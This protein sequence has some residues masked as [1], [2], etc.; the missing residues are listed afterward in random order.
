MN[1][2]DMKSLLVVNCNIAICPAGTTITDDSTT[3]T[4]SETVAPD[5]PS[6]TGNYAIAAPWERIG[7]VGDGAETVNSDVATVAACEDSGVWSNEPV[8]VSV[9]PTF[10]LRMAD[11]TQRVFQLMFGLPD[12]ALDSADGGRPW[13]GP[14]SIT[15]WLYMRISDARQGGARLLHGRMYGTLRL[16]TPPNIAQEIG[17][18]E[19]EFTPNV[20]VA[21]NTI[22]PLSLPPSS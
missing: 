8:D 10:R 22:V 2:S 12:G 7:R 11:V 18:A 21:L 14:V 6:S 15:G 20:G 9:T 19:F 16:T 13:A 5:L 17:T 1:L 3:I 4:I